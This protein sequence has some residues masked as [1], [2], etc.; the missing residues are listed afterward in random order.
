MSALNDDWFQVAR[1]S[2]GDDRA[3]RSLYG[4]SLFNEPSDGCPIF[5]VV[6]LR[7]CDMIWGDTISKLAG[8]AD[9]RGVYDHIHQSAG[10]E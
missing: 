9:L 8:K 1:K 3:R 6:S 7:A 5:G 4:A 2:V 10:K